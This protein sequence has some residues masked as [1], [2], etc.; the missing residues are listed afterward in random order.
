MT[1]T[2]AAPVATWDSFVEQFGFTAAA[3]TGAAILGLVQMQ[4]YGVTSAA[5]SLAQL[6]LALVALGCVAVLS[7]RNH[8]AVATVP[9][10][11]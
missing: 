7:Y 1:E 9:V 2:T 8:T 10:T 11:R 5:A 4:L 3:G 6:L